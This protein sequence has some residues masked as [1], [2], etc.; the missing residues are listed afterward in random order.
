M[1]AQRANIE[2]LVRRVQ[3][4]RRFK[5]THG[6][7]KLHLTDASTKAVYQLTTEGLIQ[8][9]DRETGSIETEA[10]KSDEFEFGGVSRVVPENINADV[11]KKRFVV[12][13]NALI[14]EDHYASSSSVCIISFDTLPEATEFADMVFTERKR[15]IKLMRLSNFAQTTAGYAVAGAFIALLVSGVYWFCVK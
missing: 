11:E 4:Q 10:A 9:H 15:E 1:D 7:S 13:I 14:R 5:F 6:G 8:I 2:H 3:M 12:R